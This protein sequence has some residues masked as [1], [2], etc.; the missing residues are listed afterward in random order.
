MGWEIF[1]GDEIDGA[2][3]NGYHYFSSEFPE[4]LC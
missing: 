2:E 1:F 3:A 4:T